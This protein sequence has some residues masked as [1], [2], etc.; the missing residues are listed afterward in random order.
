MSGD[1]K[2]LFPPAGGELEVFEAGEK[3]GKWREKGHVEFNTILHVII[4]CI[5]SRGANSTHPNP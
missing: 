2:M 3:E 5:H 1:C 4:Q